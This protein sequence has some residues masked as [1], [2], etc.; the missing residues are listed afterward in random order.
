MTE[1]ERE[2]KTRQEEEE[3]ERERHSG[4][5]KQVHEREI[6]RREGREGKCVDR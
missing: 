3:R 2:G 1:E 6:E 4:F 5:T